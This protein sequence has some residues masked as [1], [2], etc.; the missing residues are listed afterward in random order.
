M[1]VG[2]HQ[3]LQVSLHDFCYGAV[4]ALAI[5]NS[6]L[7]LALYYI[8]QVSAHVSQDELGNLCGHDVFMASVMLASKYLID[9][10]DKSVSAQWATIANVPV[11]RINHAETHILRLLDFRLH[12]PAETHAEATAIFNEDPLAISWSISMLQHSQQKQQQQL[13]IESLARELSLIG[14]HTPPPV[15]ALDQHRVK[16]DDALQEMESQHSH[17]DFQ[18]QLSLSA[19]AT[20]SNMYQ[21]PTR[22]VSPAHY[23]P[24]VY[25]PLQP[26]FN[27]YY[28][29]EFMFLPP[30]HGVYDALA[31]GFAAPYLLGTAQPDPY[32]YGAV[33]GP[34]LL[35]T[36]SMFS[37][38][39]YLLG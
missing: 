30:A 10:A 37:V 33:L 36:Y 11:K 7:V 31:P 28:L 17:G 8:S 15:S 32:M 14:A 38:A 2:K 27:Q 13:E 1:C 4:Q 24:F 19:G 22:A 29:E 20:G 16:T 39:G 9:E 21:I 26:N 3:G 18:R 12:M 6:F 23:Q 35:G 5:S 34:Q 25:S